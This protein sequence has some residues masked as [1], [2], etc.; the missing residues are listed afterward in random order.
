MEENVHLALVP[1]QL[2]SKHTRSASPSGH[3]RAA[4][5]HP[6][7]STSA[8][9][10]RQP[11]PPPRQASTSQGPLPDLCSLPPPVQSTR[12][13][14]RQG[15]GARAGQ[16]VRGR[17][18]RVERRR[19]GRAR[20]WPELPRVAPPDRAHRGGAG[21]GGAAT[22]GRARGSRGARPP[23]E[24]RRPRRCPHSVGRPP[25]VRL[26]RPFPPCGAPPLPLLEPAAA[27]GA[28]VACRREQ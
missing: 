4:L 28:A 27:A 8:C 11:P 21:A 13:D 3:T 23:A 19:A 12:A 20:A 15:R 5:P 26:R 9:G 6:P 25:S 22:G 24:V 10:P 2:Q 14:L 1:L 17:G 16:P 7:A 18:S